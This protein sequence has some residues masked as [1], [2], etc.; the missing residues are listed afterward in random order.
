MIIRRETLKAVLSA[1]TAN[2]T[3][4]NLDAVQIQLDGSVVATDG[5]VLLVAK[6]HDPHK[7]ED[8][9]VKDIT[10][11]KGSPDKPVLLPRSLAEKLIA[12]LPKRSA[13][14]ILDAVQVSTDGEAG[15]VISAT[16][17]EVPYVV[18]L[19]KDDNGQRFPAYAH[20][21]PAADRPAL[22]VRLA[23]NVL[24]A[25]IKAATAVQ[26][27]KTT[28]GGVI[29]FQIPTAPE[30]QGRKPGTGVD[31]VPREPDGIVIAG[32]GVQTKGDEV[33][34]TGVIM[35]CRV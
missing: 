8:F 12:A 7:D 10:E 26:G 20:I 23:V 2:E 1:T 21:L 35:P 34:V 27:R 11:F 17:L 33:D 16:D 3:R 32:I 13:V 30:H 29:T 6:E 28:T 22:T 24:Q 4:Y 18:R 9:P 25:V 14:P 19:P 15:S 5:H 31:D